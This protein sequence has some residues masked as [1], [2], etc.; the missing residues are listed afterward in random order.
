MASATP[1]WCSSPMTPP[2]RPVATAWCGCGRDGSSLRARRLPRELVVTVP[3][4]DKLTR[5][6][7]AQ[8]S[9]KAFYRNPS[10]PGDERGRYH[11]A[12]RDSPTALAQGRLHGLHGGS[13]PGLLAL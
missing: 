7:L 4:A 9:V 8:P 2:W 13:H 11:D 5:Q 10:D 1:R 6:C 12:I 3:N